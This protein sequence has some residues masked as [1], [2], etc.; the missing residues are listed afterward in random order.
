MM[1]RLSPYPFICLFVF[2]TITFQQVYPGYQGRY[3]RAVDLP[4]EQEIV[5]PRKVRSD[6]SFI[7][8]Q[9]P[10]HFEHSFYRNRTTSDNAVHYRLRIDHEE[11][12]VELYP[13]H[14]L[15]G[16]GAVVE[17]RRGSQDFLNN[18]QL[19]RLRDMQCH[20]RARVRNQSEDSALSTCY[21]LVGYI[22][23]KQAWYMIEPLAGHDITKEIEHPHIVYR[24]SPD[25]YQAD[26]MQN[27]CSVIGE[28]SRIIAKRALNPQKRMPARSNENKSYS[29][30][31]LVVLDKSLLDYH[32]EF[33]AAGLFHDVS[34]GVHMQL[35]IVRIIRLEVE[36]NEMNLS[37]NRDA[38]ATLKH[39]QE[40]QY[41]M[42]PGDDS[43]PN[44]HDCA[45]LISKLDICVSRKLC[46]F[47]GTS[48]VAGTCDPLRG[49]V[50]VRDAGLP[51]GYHIAH[52]I[53]HT[54]GMSHDV[55]RKNGCPGIV[56][57]GN[58]YAETT[59]M[60]P[61]DMYIT[62]K[63]SECSRRYLRSYIEQGLAFCLEDEP[64]DHHFPAAEM[65]PGVMYNGDD[66]CRLRY[67]L[68][69]RQCDMGVT[70]ET[71]RCAIPGR[72][73]V[74]GRKPPA[75]GTPCGEKRWCYQMKCLMVGERPGITDGGWG[76][77]SSWSRCSRTC[78]SG[79]AY[80]VR[81]CNQP[82]PSKGGSYCVGDRKRHKIC[83][84]DPCEIG[85][86]S[87]R[88][89]Q[90]AEFNDWVFPEDGKI[91]RWVAY[92]LPED[93]KA[94]ENPCALYCISETNLVASLR[95]KVVD[96]TT[97][98]R[99]IRDICVGGV[100]REIPCDLD[101]ES[102]AVE[103]VCGVCRGD[104][105]SCT[106]KQGTMSF[107]A[108]P[109][110]KKITD[111][112]VGARNIRVEEAEPTKSRIVVR[113]KNTKI[114]LIDGNR[115]GMFNVPGSKA[116]LG[117]IR[118]RQEA[119]NIPG[120]VTEDLT[121]L[122]LAKENVTLKYSLGLKQRIPRTHEFSW[123]YIDWEKCSAGCGPGE[124]VSKPR[125]IEK[126]GGLVDDKFCKNIT[127]PEAK[128]RP[129]NQAPCI[130]R[131]IIGEWQGC[132]PCTPGCKR[133]RAVKCARPVGRG[134]QDLDVIEDS[135]C[136][137]PK[138]RESASCEASRRRRQDRGAADSERGLFS[139]RSSTTT[140]QNGLIRAAKVAAKA[141]LNGAIVEDR[142][143][144]DLST[145]IGHSSNRS[146]SIGTGYVNA[147]PN[148]AMS[149]I[150]ADAM[151]NSAKTR[152][153][154][155][156]TDKKSEDTS[157]DKENMNANKIKRGEVVVDK[158]DIR[159]L[160][161]TIILERDEKNVVMNFPK[162]FDPRPPENIT[163][164]TLVGMD[165]LRYIQRIQEEARASPEVSIFRE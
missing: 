86:P 110:L 142:Y 158:E 41:T 75:E 106:L 122:V 66:Q 29:L 73:C 31:L 12:H 123:D 144:D 121:I 28:T 47:T 49:A 87:F 69:A 43:H 20:Y 19:K 98:Y 163:E 35:T 119:L 80:A 84:T 147:L 42:N 148:E 27:L 38:D 137:G 96:G 54:L 105:T 165:A 150:S 109:R 133:R 50:I 45:I 72:G 51:T 63:W 81:K 95:P 124:Q 112:P 82:S 116:W 114:I 103:D 92:N 22:K 145:W 13:N 113:T 46:G 151:R 59:V 149:L 100:C 94:S 134:E 9:I 83:A 131:W 115:L 4:N 2:I 138:P 70:C 39:F 74:T 56:Y 130:P 6:G 10:H 32:K 97:C 101:M 127:K 14:R 162:D 161:L 117:M 76:A 1:K 107:T 141:A 136:Q 85:A 108:Q 71:L 58:V 156:Q 89:V 157:N 152:R 53:G 143:P 24:K 33:D 128:V 93:L 90:C 132:T 99:G 15:L 48:T 164:F 52:Q 57:H 104:S 135:Y 64:Q 60:H 18:M 139:A 11:Y 62:K 67:R 102:T 78:G 125:C 91:H 77:W 140:R 37:I 118:P 25:E 3:T 61:G 79:V 129:C 23:T 88:D 120:P 34:L 159:N 16:P 5:I 68:D 7:S 146:C 65:L 17:R 155:S 126:I 30:E 154:R 153:D 21:G 40:W 26:A 8:H 36:E 160:T 55:Q 111:V 44:H